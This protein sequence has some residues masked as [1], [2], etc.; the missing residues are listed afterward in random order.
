M[1][2]KRILASC[3]TTT[4]NITNGGASKSTTI[5]VSAYIL[6]WLGSRCPNLVEDDLLP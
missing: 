5:D 6:T 3:Y 2:I 1:V 4:M